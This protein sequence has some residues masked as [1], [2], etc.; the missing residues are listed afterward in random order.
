VKAAPG[1][2]LMMPGPNRQLA[3]GGENRSDGRQ[4]AGGSMMRGAGLILMLALAGC[5]GLATTTPQVVVATLVRDTQSLPITALANNG[6][7]WWINADGKRVRCSKPSVES[8]KWSLRNYEISQT[9][10]DVLG[11]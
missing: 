10:P 6:S 2:L 4:Q 9:A 7:V 11:N 8:C 5:T 1:Q 3:G